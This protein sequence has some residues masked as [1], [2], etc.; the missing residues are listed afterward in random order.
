MERYS[1]EFIDNL[2][3]LLSDIVT[4][5]ELDDTRLVMFSLGS[6]RELHFYDSGKDGKYIIL[7]NN[8]KE[9]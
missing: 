2:E 4:V 9:F 5:Y 8:K 6:G 3:N 7:E 1:R